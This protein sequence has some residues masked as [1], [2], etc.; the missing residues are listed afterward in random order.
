MVEK[1]KGERV[2]LFPLLKNSLLKGGGERKEDV[3]R[4]DVD[5]SLGL[6]EMRGGYFFAKK[7]KRG[8]TNIF[9]QGKRLAD[10]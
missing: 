10:V 8:K 6:T 7:E 1:A 3:L 9:E 2:F 4:K 5:S